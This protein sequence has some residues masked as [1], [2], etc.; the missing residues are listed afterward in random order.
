MERNKRTIGTQTERIAADYLKEKGYTILEVNYRNRF[1]EID[2]IAKQGETLVF[3]E[4]KFRS[5]ETFGNPMEAVSYAKQRKIS[6][7]ALYYYAGHGYKE[8]VP[9]RFD[10]IAIYG[11]G[12]LEH[13]ENAFDFC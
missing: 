12:R 9:C 13:L 7:T 4:V 10:V 2:I 5:T 11:D 3:A 8:S 6:K 1:G